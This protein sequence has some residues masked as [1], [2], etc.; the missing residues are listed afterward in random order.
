MEESKSKVPNLSF[1][2]WQGITIEQLGYSIN[3]I[4]TFSVASLGFAV[5]LLTNKDYNPDHWGKGLFLLGC[6][7]LL[8]SLGFGIWVVLNRL[9]DFRTTAQIVKIKGRDAAV[10]SLQCMRELAEKLGRRTRKLFSW[11]I[12]TFGMGILSLIISVWITFRSKLF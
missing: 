2:R 3:L 5:N 9:K 1:V 10:E 6:F 11:Q 4:L 7:F 12:A 8:I